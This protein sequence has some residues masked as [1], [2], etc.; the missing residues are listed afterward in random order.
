LSLCLHKHFFLLRYTVCRH[1][2]FKE[3]TW[4]YSTYNSRLYLRLVC[5]LNL[6]YSFQTKL[7]VLLYA[8]FRILFII[9]IYIYS[10][11]CGYFIHSPLSF[12]K[13]TSNIAIINTVELPCSTM[14]APPRVV[15]LVFVLVEVFFYYY[16]YYYI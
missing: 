5:I 10:H 9:Y 16:Y 3:N 15:R 13:K 12:Q 2:I 4:T 8:S 7:N 6:V 14:C 11:I 1:Y